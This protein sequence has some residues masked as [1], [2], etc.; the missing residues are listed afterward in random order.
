M[1]SNWNNAW[2]GS[3]LAATVL[4]LGLSC[5][6][7]NEEEACNPES[8]MCTGVETSKATSCVVTT[9]CS[10]GGS[11][12]CG[13]AG[14]C[15]PT[16]NASSIEP[17]IITLDSLLLVGDTLSL[18]TVGQYKDITVSDLVF[19]YRI[20]SDAGEGQAITVSPE[21]VVTAV[22][23][24]E[25]KIYAGLADSNNE[26]NP[27][28][29]RVMDTNPQAGQVEVIVVDAQTM[30]P[31]SNAQVVLTGTDALN[32]AALTNEKGTVLL[33]KDGS[34]E[35]VSVHIF[36]R[37]FSYVT[38]VSVA[39]E[40]V[41]AH[42]KPTKKLFIIQED[43]EDIDCSQP[44]KLEFDL[45]HVDG[46]Q[47]MPNFGLI[48]NALGEV[49]VALS[50]FSY[51]DLLDLNL[52]QILGL[53]IMR[54]LS[55]L[56]SF[57]V[58]DDPVGVP[59]NLYLKFNDIDVVDRYYLFGEPGPRTAWSL[60]G[61][62]SFTDIAQPILQALGEGEPDI[63]AII[64][65][66]LPF[67]E[68]FSSGLVPDLALTS[69]PKTKLPQRD[70]ELRYNANIEVRAQVPE[71]PML[72]AITDEYQP[73]GEAKWL[74]GVLLVGG[75]QIAGQGLAITGIT[76]GLDTLDA[77][78]NLPDGLVDTNQTT[79]EVDPFRLKL[80]SAHSGVQGG[81]SGYTFLAM[82]VGFNGEAADRVALSALVY[83][84]ALGAEPPVDLVFDHPD[85]L[86]LSET[87]K[88]SA[89]NELN[90]VALIVRQCTRQGGGEQAAQRTHSA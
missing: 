83:N 15:V 45:D 12:V 76:A 3:F 43:E 53:D 8:G 6:G 72:T 69:T 41:L 77:S 75:I 63:G 26:S 78:V 40:T 57:G 18:L 47:G 70:I 42:L 61:R 34:T 86:T 50:G 87:S 35:V 11:S 85:F 84:T 20:E 16:P 49:S 65:A 59:S 51:G 88:Y 71:L 10:V 82:A 74:D 5:S 7:D 73:V 1:L 25:A 31:V 9:H 24:G 22:A 21:G 32:K 58:S 29:V 80:A 56:S 90:S 33:N 48:D 30:L 89:G 39:Q 64:T 52:D 17:K 62:V 81:R 14:V 38:Y 28:T 19:T 66:V 2:F 13:P 4:C 23:A 54:C 27:L 44:T 46:I 79:T 36:H 55:G 68:N 67:F 37:E 60:G